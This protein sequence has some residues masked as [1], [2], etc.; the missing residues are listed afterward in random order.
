VRIEKLKSTQQWELEI[1]DISKHGAPGIPKAAVMKAFK[2]HH[3]QKFKF[4]FYLRLFSRIHSM[5]FNDLLLV[6]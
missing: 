2:V 4:P 3:L 5:L 1:S 6:I